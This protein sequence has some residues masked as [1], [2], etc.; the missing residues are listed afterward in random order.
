MLCAM[1]M[2]RCGRDRKVV[3]FTTLYAISAYH[4]KSCEF[5]PLSWLGALHT[6][7]SDKVF[8]L[9]ATGPWFSPVSSTN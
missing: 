9:F 6:T 3:G 1:Y 8:Q 4:H 5:E 2:D 7:L